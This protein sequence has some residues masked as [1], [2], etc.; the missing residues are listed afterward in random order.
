MKYLVK[1]LNKTLVLL[2]LIATALPQLGKAQASNAKILPEPGYYNMQIGDLPVTVLSDG[3]N[4][5]DLGTLLLNAK[6]G[7][8]K[9][10]FAENFLGTI[11]EASDNAFLI[12]TGGKLVLVDVGCGDLLGPSFGQLTKSLQNAGVQPEQIDAVLLTH[13]HPDHCGGLMRNG[14]MVFPNATVYIAKAESDF[15]LSEDHLK[16]APP[17]FKLYFE[18]AQN[19]ALPYVK[20]GKVITFNPDD[21]L[22]PG[23]TVVSTPGH[24]PG[25]T[26]YTIESNGEKL[27]ILGDLIHAAAIQFADPDI[28]ISFDSDPKQAVIT[29]KRCF[30]DAAKG[31]YLIAGEHL[32]FPGVGHVKVD[33][34][35]YEFIPANYSTLVSK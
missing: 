31:K 10:I 9:N 27:L 6:P 5:L 13:M 34:K 15:W 7:Q 23:I 32:S 35:G 8:L 11:V 17:A 29:R 21:N 12:R 30:A 26:S 20:A 33:G 22:F 16:N 24:T 28:A 25:H 18:Y 4:P 2:L 3:T 19:S 14:K 1:I